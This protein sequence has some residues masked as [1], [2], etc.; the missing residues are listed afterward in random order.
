MIHYGYY[1]INVEIGTR[2]SMGQNRTGQFYISS[3]DF[4][5]YLPTLGN[6]RISVPWHPVGGDSKLAMGN[7]TS[8]RLGCTRP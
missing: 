4:N 3:R 5:K 6:L 8:D 2:P 1:K 7:K